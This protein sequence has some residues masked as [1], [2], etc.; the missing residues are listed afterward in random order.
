MERKK[1]DKLYLTYNRYMYIKIYRIKV[2]T[3]PPRREFWSRDRC[4]VTA[5]CKQHGDSELHVSFLD[6]QYA[7]P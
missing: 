2:R 1:K 4:F 7:K 5:H 3:S 6:K